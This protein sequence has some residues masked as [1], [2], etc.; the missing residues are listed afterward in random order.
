MPTPE[1]QQRVVQALDHLNPY[2]EE[3]YPRHKKR[4]KGMQMF[5]DDLAYSAGHGTARPTLK[6]SSTRGLHFL[7]GWNMG[8]ALTYPIMVDHQP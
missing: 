6:I 2:I 8:Y 5:A 3:C 4:G 1:Y 7:A